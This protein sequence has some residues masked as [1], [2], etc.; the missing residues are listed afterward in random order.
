LVRFLG[1]QKMNRYKL[2]KKNRGAIYRDELDEVKVIMIY[3]EQNAKMKLTLLKKQ[4]DDC[5]FPDSDILLNLQYDSQKA[6]Y[7]TID[8]TEGK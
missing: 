6:I 8:P 7:N 4:V 3:G 1:E 5:N 2:K